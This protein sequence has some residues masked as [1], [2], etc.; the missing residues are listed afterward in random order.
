M[1]LFVYLTVGTNKSHLQYFMSMINARNPA[2]KTTSC[3]RV[4]LNAN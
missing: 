1:Q 2:A 4:I 3:E